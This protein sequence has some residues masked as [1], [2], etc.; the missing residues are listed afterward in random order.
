MKSTQDSSALE[1][2]ENG[3]GKI[4][5]HPE[6]DALIH[7]LLK[8]LSEHGLDQTIHYIITEIKE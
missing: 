1:Y 5:I 7:H 4:L 3:R 8:Y 2:Y 6:T